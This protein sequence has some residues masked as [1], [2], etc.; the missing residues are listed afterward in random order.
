MRKQI[1][2]IKIIDLFKYLLL[3]IIIAVLLW[4]L[5]RYLVLEYVPIPHWIFY[6]VAG[7]ASYFILK[8]F[9]IGTVLAYKAFAPLSVRS[10]C[11]FQPTCSTYMIMAIQKYGFAFGVYKG[12]RRLLRCKPPNGGVDYP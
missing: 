4:T 12:I 1:R 9:T 11:R 5:V 7:V 10:R 6:V 2:E 8:Y 3:P